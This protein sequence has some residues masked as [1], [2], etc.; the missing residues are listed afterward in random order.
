MNTICFIGYPRCTTCIKAYKAIQEMGLE[1]Q[2]RN[3]QTE[4]P[5]KEEIQ[6]WIAQGVELKNLFNTSGKLYRELNVKE[7]RKTSSDEELIDLLSQNGMLVKRPIVIG[8]NKIIVGNKISEYE[9]LK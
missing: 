4:N 3:I 2:Y 7:K 1:V 6:E 8:N 5:T 9:S